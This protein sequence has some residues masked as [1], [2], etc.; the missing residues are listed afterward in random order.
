MKVLITGGNGFIGRHTRAELHACGYEVLVFDRHDHYSSL[1]EFFLGDIRDA[2]AVNEA[3]AHSDA[4]IHLAGVLGTAETIAN[5]RPAAET[6]VLGGLNVLEAAAQYGLPGVNIAVGN[7]WMNN[8][9]AITKN[10]VERFSRMFV[11]ER[12]LPVTNVR[13][14]NAYGPLQSVA[15]PYGNSKVRKIMPS[16]VCRALLGHP[17]EIYGDGEQ[18][19]DMI[20]VQDV[21]TVLV[22]ALEAT[23][24]NGALPETIEA[25]T[26]RPTTVN[27]IA[28]AVQKTALE[29]YGVESEIRHL[30]MRS[31]EPDRSVV[32]ANTDMLVDYDIIDPNSLL[33]LEEGLVP[34]AEYFMEYLNGQ[35]YS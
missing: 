12:G 9:Y 27:F 5:P 35:G 23:I 13:A 15:Q 19:M 21:A 10:S 33:S 6:N 30:P 29:L 3:M 18:I 25:G 17:I 7:W 34:T 2:V 8:T 24:N 26:G 4:W 22:N 16:F 32:L 20:Y 28:E 11:K 14:L 1:D 31:G